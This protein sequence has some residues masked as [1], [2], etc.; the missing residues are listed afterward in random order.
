ML[1]PHCSPQSA[2]GNKLYIER[3]QRALLWLKANKTR[4]TK[5]TVN[6]SSEEC[7]HQITPPPPP[8]LSRRP[9]KAH[10]ESVKSRSTRKRWSWLVD[11][12]GTKTSPMEVAIKLTSP[13]GVVVASQIRARAHLS[14]YYC[15]CCYA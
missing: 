11:A 10:R 5:H 13:E 6:L 14:D 12:H 8:P 3:S 4:T 15:C 7:S 1:P 9:Y 2:L